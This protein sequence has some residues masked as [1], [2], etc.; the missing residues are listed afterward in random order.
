MTAAQWFASTYKG[1]PTD[2]KAIIEAAF[3]FATAQERERCANVCGEFTKVWLDPL[4]IAA[5]EWI[6]IGIN[7]E[8]K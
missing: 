7:G 1:A 5:A 3:D 4:A 6:A 2:T 8:T